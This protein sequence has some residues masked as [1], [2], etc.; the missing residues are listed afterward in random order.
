MALQETLDELTERRVAYTARR[1]A[2]EEELRAL[3][4]EKLAAE[5][6]SIEGIIVKASREGVFA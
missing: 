3:R 2:I 5:Q 4:K 6:A 1:A